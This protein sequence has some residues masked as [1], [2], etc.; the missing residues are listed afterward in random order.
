MAYSVENLGAVHL[1]L[2]T[3]TVT[4]APGEIREVTEV[5]T[6][7][8]D[9]QKA[10]RI[11]ITRIHSDSGQDDAKYVEVINQLV[12][13]RPTTVGILNVELKDANTWYLIS[14]QIQDVLA[15]RFQI[16]RADPPVPF[17]YTYLTDQSKFMSGVPGEF[18]TADVSFPALFA[19]CPEHPGQIAELEFWLK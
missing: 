7:E 16:R 14:G 18:I 10:G 19:R 3:S 13:Q 15:W 1:L 11:A 8:L 6:R 5:G 4:L 9:L 12:I 2:P 17:D